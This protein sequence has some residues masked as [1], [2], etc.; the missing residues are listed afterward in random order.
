MDDTGSRDTRRET[1]PAV[2]LKCRQ[3]E[4]EPITGRPGTYQPRA[5]TIS[6]RIRATKRQGESIGNHHQQ[7]SMHCD[8][9]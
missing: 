7:D 8:L 6:S 2:T 4:K 9:D 3:R 1:I 5:G